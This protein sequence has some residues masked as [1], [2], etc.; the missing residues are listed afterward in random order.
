MWAPGL[1]FADALAK[2]NGP[3][4]NELE[5]HERTHSEQHIEEPLEPFELLRSDIMWQ[6]Q[7]WWAHEG[8]EVRPL[9]SAFGFRRLGF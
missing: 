7:H 5:H 6:R 9:V 2:P 4:A 8:E 1:R 3:L